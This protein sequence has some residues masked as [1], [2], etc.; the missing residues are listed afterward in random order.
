MFS[1]IWLFSSMEN[2]LSHL[3][4]SAEPQGAGLEVAADRRSAGISP[5]LLNNIGEAL[6]AL[7]LLRPTAFL[8]L[9]RAR[10]EQ[11]GPSSPPAG[12]QGSAG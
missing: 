11:P 8:S 9:L 2:I 1:L 3:L 7:T 12:S 5:R 10:G 4:S 6:G